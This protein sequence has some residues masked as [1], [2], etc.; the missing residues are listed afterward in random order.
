MQRGTRFSI[1]SEAQSVRPDLEWIYKTAPI[2]LAFLS[3][4]CRY[5]MINEHLTEICGI[6]IAEHIGRSV[7]ETVPQ[8]AEQVEQIVATIRRTGEPII[9][10]EVNG[11]RPDGSNVERVWIT[12]WHPLKEPDGKVIGVNV[13][14]EEITERKR[15]EA[16]L[17]A[18]QE[19]LRRL[20]EGL[21]ERVEAQAKE[22]DRIWMLSQDLLVVTDTQASI[23]NVNP[24]WTAILG[25]SAEE[26]IGTSIEQLI[27]PEDRERSRAELAGL[28]AGQKTRHFEN[29]LAGNRGFHRLLSWFAVEDRGHIYAAG[30]DITDLKEAQDQ[31][32][33]L[34]RRLAEAARRTA[35]GEMA[36]S[37][38][39]EINQPLGAVVANASAGLR[40]LASSPPNL[41]D[42]REALA[43]IVKAGHRAGEV[44]G[45]IRAMFRNDRQQ[46]IRLDVNDIIREVLAL[47]HGE[48]NHHS[49]QV[50]T[51]LAE[52]LPRVVAIRVQLQQVVL[53]LVNNAIEAMR[54]TK[55]EARLISMSSELREPGGIRVLVEDSGPGIDPDH[56][57]RI[58][59]PFFTTKRTGMGMGLSI[60]RSIIEAHGGHLSASR[61]RGGGSVFEIMLPADELLQAG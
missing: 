50:T 22:R 25:W 2:G 16:A 53:N 31:L 52:A 41:A 20:N 17:A 40:F 47:I 10:V 61:A 43:E 33:G 37:I 36:A 24:A 29:R 8:V 30:R 45:G 42:T 51:S 57:D 49:I 44:I 39:H 54:A 32:H 6:S 11:Q 18:S 9:G 15:A 3:T 28:V 12:Y 27:H 4:D 5:V 1:A 48:L 23:L 35:M 13:A 14:A 59:D 55:R 19:H 56:L 7:R 38:A 46:K 34:R 21:A 58:F 60:C 26:L